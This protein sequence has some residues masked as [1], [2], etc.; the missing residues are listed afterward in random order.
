[1]F[2]K[3]R[4]DQHWVRS[5]IEGTVVDANDNALIDEE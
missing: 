1:M 2:K 3:R 5:D 4:K